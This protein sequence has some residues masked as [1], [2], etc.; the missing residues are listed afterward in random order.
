MLCATF[1]LHAD[2][3]RVHTYLFVCL[4]VCMYVCMY[5]CMYV[6]I[7]VRNTLRH[8]GRMSQGSGFMVRYVLTDI[9]LYICAS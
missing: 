2:N 6:F 8:I 9:V 3:K 1:H 5:L 4:Y 7:Y